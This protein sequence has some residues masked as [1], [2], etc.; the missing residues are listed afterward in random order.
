MAPGQTPAGVEPGGQVE[1]VRRRVLGPVL[2]H[3][4][5]DGQVLL[6][7]TDGAG[8]DGT[9]PLGRIGQV[10]VE[11]GEHGR[12]LVAARR[13]AVGADRHG[14]GGH[15]GLVGELVTIEHVGPQCA[16]AQ[17]EHHVVDGAAERRLERP[18]VLERHPGEAHGAQ[19]AERTAPR[20]V[21]RP[22]R[23]RSHLPLRVPA[24][25]DHPVH[26]LGRLADQLGQGDGL[27]ETGG[28]GMAQQ[29][30]V[31]GDVVGLAVHRRGWVGRLRLEV[32]QVDHQLGAGGTVDGRVVHLGDHADAVLLQALDDPQLPEGAGPVEGGAGD[33]AGQLAE[34]AASA[35]GG[36]GDAV[37]VKVEVEVGIFDPHRVGE[38]QGHLHQP[39]SERRHQV[40]PPADELLDV[41]EG[42]AA[43][44]RGRVE[45][46]G[47]GHVHV[48]GGVLEVEEGGV[49]PG[50][51][52]HVRSSKSV[53]GVCQ[54][55][56]GGVRIT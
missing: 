55:R 32:E 35:G 36:A 9:D 33:L 50:Q 1:R 8:L 44:D 38:V 5:T 7:G 48:V 23:C 21:G 18:H 13:L 10:G 14:A 11:R 37:D 53:P 34:L 41:L 24:A 29:L 28:G 6:L 54:S 52:F 47:H 25:L 46:H 20:G 19:W 17:P 51:S 42:V 49:E 30:E 31:V 15:E 40:D 26:G 45:H 43:G 22:Q 2:E 39:A 56:M 3:V 12:H 16:G 4:G 27:A